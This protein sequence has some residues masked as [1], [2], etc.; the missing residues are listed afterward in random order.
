MKGKKGQIGGL[1]SV[2]AVL[3]VISVLLSASFFII[4]EFLELDELTDTPVSV[5]N[6]TLSSV[7]GAGVLVTNAGANGFN[8][9]LVISVANASGG[10][11]ISDGNYTTTSDGYVYSSTSGGYNNTD[12][13]VT[14]DYNYGETSWEG[15]NSTMT[16]ITT[17]PALLGLI[18][19]IIMT[20]I[21]LGIVVNI[22]GKTSGA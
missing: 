4:Q 20:M 21:V 22:S 9:F 3:I 8:G 15:V 16:A 14:Y 19:V 2:I 11:A 18:I 7:T 1:K 12:W 6:E 13:N 17:I 5:V 10:E